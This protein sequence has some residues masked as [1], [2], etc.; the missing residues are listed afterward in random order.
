MPKRIRDNRK[1]IQA[2]NVSHHLLHDLADKRAE[3]HGETVSLAATLHL[4]L[5]CLDDVHSGKQEQM[6]QQVT[7]NAIRAVVANLSD[8][9][10]IVTG[11][12]IDAANEVAEVHTES[13]RRVGI[14]LPRM[15]GVGR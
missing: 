7:L 9:G 10:I 3:K 11:M 12:T 4:A 2:W 1:P 6:L 15:T 5:M 14:N 13:G 8:G